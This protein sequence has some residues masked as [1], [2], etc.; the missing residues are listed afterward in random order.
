MKVQLLRF[1]FTLTQNHI[2]T[3]SKETSLRVK[4]LSVY[5]F[6]YLIPFLNLNFISSCHDEANQSIYTH[7]VRCQKYI[8]YDL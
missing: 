7:T 2:I 8:V 6:F 3:F 1:T 4:F 5:M